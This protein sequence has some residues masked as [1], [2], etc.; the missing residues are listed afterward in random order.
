MPSLG[1][2]KGIAGH[3]PHGG[4]ELRAGAAHTLIAASFSGPPR[5]VR[6]APASDLATSKR[7][8]SRAA[9][10]HTKAIERRHTESAGHHTNILFMAIKTGVATMA[11][12][13]PKPFDPKQ[14]KPELENAEEALKD[15]KLA[16]ESG[17][18]QINRGEHL[19]DTADA[20]HTITH[21]VPGKTGP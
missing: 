18:G 5:I 2:G 7:L 13:S 17:K 21:Q 4:R 3:H 19:D 10:G 12:P 20:H 14:I 1:R 9:L 15:A 6:F 16:T 11:R 8:V